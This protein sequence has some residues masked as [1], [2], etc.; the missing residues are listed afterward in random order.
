MILSFSVVSVSAIKKGQEPLFLEVFIDG[1]ME[2]FAVYKRLYS[3]IIF[4]M[5]NYLCR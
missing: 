1:K 5:E 3:L 2:N 4:Y